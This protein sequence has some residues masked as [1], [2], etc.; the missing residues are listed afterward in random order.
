MKLTRSMF[1]LFAAV[2]LLPSSVM[3]SAIAFGDVMVSLRNGTVREYTQ[4]GVLVQTLNTGR[5]GELDGSAF[6]SAGN[7]YQS[8]GFTGG[9]VVKFNNNGILQGTFG[10]G[11]SGE[12]ES[13]VFGSA[14]NVFVGEADTALMKEFS[15]TGAPISSFTLV[16]QDRG[17]DWVELA[18]DQKTIYYT[19]EGSQIKRFDTST[20][21]QLTD[22]SNVGGTEYALRLLSDGSVLVANT[23]DVLHISSTGTILKTYLPNSGL[24][25]ALN[26][27]PDGTSFWT[28]EYLTGTVEKVDIAT[29]NVLQSFNV[30][31]GVSGLSLLGEIHQSQ[32]PEPSTWLLLGAGL[33]SL[34]FGRM[35]TTR[36]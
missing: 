8:A 21:T 30:G 1:G 2:T 35:R 13:L 17:T 19:S 33:A 6:D 7:F 10:S 24:L 18:A 15:A 11:Y 31:Q 23:I 32:S 22:F 4:T 20:N 9:D 26:L 5:T 12:P 36:R 25:F 14:G 34:A 27:D 3:A 16:R 29:G 28:A